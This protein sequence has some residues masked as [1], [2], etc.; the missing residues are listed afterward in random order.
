MVCR[1]RVVEIKVLEFIACVLAQKVGLF[2]RFHPFSDDG[3][4]QHPAQ[5]DDGFGLPFVE[6]AA[7]DVPDEGAID[8]DGINRELFELGQRGVTEAKVV[9][10]NPNA[11]AR[12]VV[13]DFHGGIDIAHQQGFG[14]VQFQK[15][16]IHA[17]VGQY[18]R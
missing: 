16:W 5:G 15:A 11:S 10:G 4:A 7:G 3:L 9:D 12:E 17:R 6:G 8:L 1:C 14:D 13:Q 18:C 2:L